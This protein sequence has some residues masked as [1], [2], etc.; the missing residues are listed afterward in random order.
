MKSFQFGRA[1]KKFVSTCLSPVRLPSF[2]F[3]FHKNVKSVALTYLI[4]LFCFGSIECKKDSVGNWR[5]DR[6]TRLA[7]TTWHEQ[8]SYPSFP[9]LQACIGRELQDRCNV[10]LTSSTAV[11]LGAAK[12]FKNRSQKLGVPFSHRGPQK[13]VSLVCQVQ[14]FP[15]CLALPLRIPHSYNFLAWPLAVFPRP[16][17]SS[18]PFPCRDSCKCFPSCCLPAILYLAN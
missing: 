17:N 8:T 5:D 4:L 6:S 13:Q 14:T 3:F 16:S 9:R 10:G 15:C 1:S 11:L 7:T 12:R 18:S 2:V